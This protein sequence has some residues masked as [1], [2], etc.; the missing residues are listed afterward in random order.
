MKL[1]RLILVNWGQLRPGNFDMGDMTLLTGETGSGK[2]TML[3]GLQT[4]M[5]AANKGIMNYNPGQDEVMQGQRRSKT[6]RTLESYV[7]GAEYNNFSRKDGAQGFM[8]A[9]FR[10]SKGEEHLKPFTALVGASARVEGSGESRQAKLENIAFVIVDDAALTFEDFIKDTEANE[11]VSV[12]RIVRHL[13]TKYSLVRDFNEK[14][15][16]YLCALYGRFRGKSS[17]PKDEAT[18]AAKAWVQSIAYRPIG[19]VHELVRDEILDFDEKQLQQDIERIGGLMRQV[20]NLRHESMRLQANVGKLVKLQTT[21]ATANSAHESHVIQG[22]LV[23]KLQ[24]KA[25]EDAVNTRKKQIAKAVEV[26]EEESTRIKSWNGRVDVLDAQRVTLTAR[27]QGIPVHNQKIELDTSLAKAT[28]A[29]RAYLESLT[30]SLRAAALLEQRAREL[31]S[32]AVPDSCKLLRVS[33][34]AVGRAVAEIDFSRLAA[35]Q[36]KILADSAAEE[37]NVG[38]LYQLSQAFGGINQGI[39]GLYDAL[40]GQGDS[41]TLAVA[42]D[43]S[44]VGQAK[45]KA[46]DRVRDLSSQRAKLAQGK[47][48]YPPMVERALTLLNEQFP[49]ASAQVLCDLVEPKSEKWQSAIE[50][51]IDGARFNLIVQTAWE[52]QCTDFLKAKGIFAKVVQGTLCLKGA[53]SKRLPSDSVVHEL[54]SDNPIAWAYLVDQFGAVLK[55][56]NTEELRN[57]SRGITLEGVASGGRT[58]FPLK[59]VTN[60]FGQK[61]RQAALERVTRELGTAQEDAGNWASVKAF[62]DGIKVSLQGLKQPHF[63]SNPLREAGNI[64]EKTREALASLDITELKGMEESLAAIVKEITE[65]RGSIEAA[66]TRKGEQNEI[67]K[68][69]NAS[70]KALQFERQKHLEAFESQI[71]KVKHLVEVN[72]ALNYPTLSAEVDAKLANAALTLEDAKE[73]LKDIETKPGHLLVDVRELLSEYNT[74]AKADER[75]IVALQQ[76]QDTLLFDANY[77][78]LV[79]LEQSVVKV[80]DGLR[81]IGLYNNSRELDK[82]ERSFHDVFTK[83]FC[84]EIKSRVDEGIRTLRQMNAELKNLKFGSDSFSIDWSRW[85]PEFEDYL[86]FFEAVTKLADSA[87]PLDLFGEVTLSE[88]HMQIRDRLVKLLLDDDHERATKEL[89]RIADYRN[90]RHYDIIND[91]SSGGRVKLSEWGTGSGGQLETPAYIVRAAVVTNRLKLFEKAPSLKL[92]VNDESFAKMDEPRARAVLGFLRDKLDLQVISAMPTMKAG[93]LKDEFNREYSFTR[94]KNVPNGELDFVSECDERIFKSDKMRELWERQRVLAREKAKQLFDSTN[95]EEGPVQL[96]A[97][98]K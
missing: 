40:V 37:L 87:E 55:V 31:T 11:Y 46:D 24:L 64:I 23:A 15:M 93:A 41:V 50:S 51:Y 30:L 47:V 57:S 95:P 33:V 74:Q 5:T 59:E 53:D 48:P 98:A 88:K 42:S 17:V 75:F 12:D 9:V 19:S 70:I 71:Q 16:D 10:P 1:D 26:E 80:L 68:T 52:R 8:A 92:L 45:S 69:A 49:Q 83:Q 82:A 43:S 39:D 44:T 38:G 97:E 2:S 91:T 77:A 21:I 79:A 78:V 29:A 90:Y 22:M 35:C 84:V 7:V 63:D 66:A 18:N 14:K 32:K 94:L 58:M 89:L 73:S 56:A 28:A 65:F 25:N 34:E 76:R 62:L 4:I 85:E 72:H 27:L 36:E 13:Q 54:K 60:V 20:S 6:K 67:V 81:S 61:S 96:V 3:D 86:G